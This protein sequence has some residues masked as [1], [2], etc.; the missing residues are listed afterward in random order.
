MNEIPVLL[1][2]DDEVDARL[3]VE[4]I[5]RCRSPFAE[6]LR[7][8]HADC[9]AAATEMAKSKQYHVVLLDLGLPEGRGIETLIAWREAFPFTPV[10]VL[11]GLSDENVAADALKA[12]AQDYLL[13]DELDGNRVSRSV[14]YAIE[15]RR[16]ENRMR[17]AERES[18][19]ALAAAK[20]AEARAA[21]ADEMRKAKEAAEA[22][23]QAKSEFLANMSHE[24]RTPLH[25]ILS[26]ARFGLEKYQTATPEKIKSYFERIDQSSQTLLVLVNDLLDLS[27]L[28]AGQMQL[29]LEM[30]DIADRANAICEELQLLLREKQITIRKRYEFEEMV[31]ADRTRIDQV[32]RNLI[33][34]AIKFSPVAAAI[35]IAIQ[36]TR[37]IENTPCLRVSITDEGPGVPADEREMIFSKF[38]QST[39]TKSAA[40]GTGLGLA[41]CN[42]IIQQHAGRIWT[43][44]AECGGSKFSFELSCAVQQ[45]ASGDHPVSAISASMPQSVGL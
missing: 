43:E 6:L 7:F 29:E 37:N 36:A 24:L 12:G 18:L 3:V 10:I 41:I 39:A 32:L 38:R 23:N 31:C 33:A 2:E 14:R 8:E 27:K 30:V 40:G 9:L 19:R 11:T 28:E 35:E 13:K 16:T 44:P 45:P 21:L 5:R 4:A 17:K 15:R 20:E 1:I 25:G 22:A 42:Q 34:N 26:F